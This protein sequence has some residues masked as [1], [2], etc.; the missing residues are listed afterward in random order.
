MDMSNMKNIVVLKNLPSNVIEEAIV[1]IKENKKIKNYQKAEIENGKAQKN[2]KNIKDI[3]S[4][5][6]S[7]KAEKEYIVK[8]AEMVIANYISELEQKSTKGKNQLKTLQ[9]RY[10]KS[11]QL[12]FL[13]GF[14]TVLS[15]CISIII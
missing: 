1:V 5:E 14:A 6:K 12:N 13:L 15:I 10:K 4:K 2:R 3:T 8:E 9:K 7:E 11:L